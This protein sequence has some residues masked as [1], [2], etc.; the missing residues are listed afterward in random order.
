MENPF[1]RSTSVWGPK[2]PK[3][4]EKCDGKGLIASVDKDCHLE[5]DY[6]LECDGDGYIPVKQ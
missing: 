3:K 6:C 2:P 4:C 1:E 5:A